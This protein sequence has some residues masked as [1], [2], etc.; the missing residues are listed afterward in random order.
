MDFGLLQVA[1]PGGGG[2]FD[3]ADRTA[4]EFDRCDSHVFDFDSFVGQ[5]RRDCTNLGHFAHEPVQQVDVVNSLV[6]VGSSPIQSP[7]AAPAPL[8][9][10]LLGAPP[11]HIGVTQGQ[12]AEPAF[13]DRFL[14]RDVG[15][16][17]P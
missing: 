11:L 16:A 17:E 13:V 8:I 3:R 15:G 14:E 4:L 5:R 12:L 2:A 7:R 6:H 10:I 9:V 1:G